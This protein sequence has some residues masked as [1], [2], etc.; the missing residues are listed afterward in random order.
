[1]LVGL[2]NILRNSSRMGGFRSPS[3]L[4]SQLP[5]LLTPRD[6]GIQRYKNWYTVAI[7]GLFP[8]LGFW[9]TDRSEWLE[10]QAQKSLFVWEIERPSGKITIPRSWLLFKVFSWIE[11]K[12]NSEFMASLTSFSLP[13]SSLPWSSMLDKVPVNKRWEKVLGQWNSTGSHPELK[14]EKPH[15]FR[16]CVGWEQDRKLDTS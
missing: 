14:L 2:T 9:P 5:E 3:T 10:G 8:L 6:K 4:T 1:M 7:P 16:K 13:C 11:S 15:L 12:N